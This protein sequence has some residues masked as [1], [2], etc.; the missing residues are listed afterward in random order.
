[1]ERWRQGLRL[2][3]HL[4][5][6]FGEAVADSQAGQE[7]KNSKANRSASLP[8]P[9]AAPPPAPVSPV[10]PDD[11]QQVAQNPGQ[12]V[13]VAKARPRAGPPPAQ[14]EIMPKIPRRAASHTP[15]IERTP[16]LR[17]RAQPT[18][19]P[20][21]RLCA[22]AGCQPAATARC[23]GCQPTKWGR[24]RWQRAATIGPAGSGGA[25]AN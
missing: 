1:M 7:K 5:P 14:P 23:A 19:K 16:E 6:S 10:R 2:F 3:P 13:P 20:P 11:S 9:S 21:E 22:A 4:L 24:T 17:L 18:M 12:S 15:P 8:P 25:A